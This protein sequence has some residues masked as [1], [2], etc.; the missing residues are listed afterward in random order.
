MTYGKNQQA[1]LNFLHK[2]P[3]KWHKIKRRKAL[4][5]AKG[6]SKIV[7]GNV[8]YSNCHVLMA[9]PQMLVKQS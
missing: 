8:I 3:N 1:L 6:L 5:A 9:M 4:E 7:D 2:H